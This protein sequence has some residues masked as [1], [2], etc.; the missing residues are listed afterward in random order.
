MAQLA[1]LV[2]LP[3]NSLELNY[4][5]K[6]V[7]VNQALR[8]NQKKLKNRLR[9]STMHFF[10]TYTSF[11]SINLRVVGYSSIL[12]SACQSLLKVFHKIYK[13]LSSGIE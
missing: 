4:D 10:I 13:F 8:K 6:T 1:L 11:Q 12:N 2:I 9:T 7:L 3:V 5:E